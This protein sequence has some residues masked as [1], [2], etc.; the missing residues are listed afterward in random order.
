MLLHLPHISCLVLASDLDPSSNLN[1][2]VEN[3]NKDH[4]PLSENE[5]QTNPDIILVRKQQQQLEKLEEL[6]KNLTQIVSRLEDRFSE[7]PEKVEKLPL[8]S[9]DDEKREVEKIKEGL[10]GKEKV[11]SG[12]GP[13]TVSVT[14][15][16]TFWSERFQFV[17]AVKLG[18]SPSCINVLPFKDFE[19]LSKYVAVGDDKGKVYVFLRNGDVSMEFDALSELQ[20]ESSSVTAMVSYLSVYKNESIIVSGYESG[21]VFMHRVW[22]VSNSDEWSS[23]HVEMVGRFEI[24]EGGRSRINVLEVHHVGRKRYILAI[25]GSG[26]I[27]VFREDGTV[28]GSAVPSRQP[29]AFLK[30]RL[31]FLTETGAGSL[32]LRTMK[33]KESQCEGLNN[34]IAKN[35]VFDA[36]DRSKAYGFTQEGDLIHT[37]LM[38]DIVNF[39]CR[40]RSK[41][42]MDLD[43]PLALHAMKG[44][45]LIANQEKIFVY[46]VS[47]QHYVWAGGLRLSF[48]VG[49]DEII[50]SFLNQQVADVNDE[51]R[52][53]IPL[54]TS[55][56]EKL[57]ILS[58][59]NGYVAIYRSNLPSFKSEFN[60]ILWTSPVLFFILFLFGAWQF[61]ANKKEALTSWGP[62]DPFSSTSVTNGAPLGS[63]TGER[64]FT[65][66]SRNADIMDLRGS[67]LRA[68][69]RRFSP[70]RY[71]G[72]SASPYRPS[73]DAD[74]RPSPIDPR[75]RTTSELKFRG[76]SIETT[77]VPKRREGIY[78]NSQVINDSN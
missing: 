30:Q 7:I 3:D 77:S 19:G 74:S 28:Y 57:V 78:V 75:F 35:Y 34:S 56:Y 53:A 59:G 52:M 31:L 29:L 12:A 42:K 36:I 15:Y 32:D 27:T 9:A 21:I 49:L 47:S 45:L 67:G 76:S 2:V 23:L 60:G 11:A 48:S 33:L 22:E 61:F 50:A 8:L 20:F 6:V 24:S 55:D 1:S 13:G 62:D 71:S 17:S 26:K 46:N 4:V 38:G 68:P 69:S 65:D 70:P 16:S 58:L 40:I 54:L 72:G 43:E 14:K 10:N 39:K 44:Y 18:T 5:Y 41:R 73:P 64:S 51:K 66:S 25:D 63:G 37:L